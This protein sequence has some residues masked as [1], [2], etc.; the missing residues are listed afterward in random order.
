MIGRALVLIAFVVPTLVAADRMRPLDVSPAGRLDE[1]P[2]DLGRWRG[3]PAPA[4]DDQT[5]RILAADDI[6]NRDYVAGGEARAYVYVGYYR[7]QMRGASIHSPLN[8]LP[9]AGW[10]VETAE[11]VPFADGAARR[12][13]IRKGGDWLLVMYWYQTAGRV[14]GDEYRSA[15]YAAVDTIRDRRN[16]A[17]IVRVIVPLD[18]RAESRAVRLAAEV[19]GLLEPQVRRILF[20][21]A[22]HDEG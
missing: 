22:S 17:A 19:A 14:E 11:R 4:F 18:P 12:V 5:L 8:C 2:W 9:G 21:P 13:R 10:A 3:S 1:I 6:L 20:P 16:D 15:F 7:S